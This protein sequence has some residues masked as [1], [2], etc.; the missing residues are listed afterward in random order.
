MPNL[1]ALNSHPYC[2]HSALIGERKRSWQNVNHV[3]HSFGKTVRRAR[4]EYFLYVEAG[5][6][7]G[8]VGTSLEGVWFAV[9]GVGQKWRN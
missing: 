9:L 1:V 8:V 3:L 7:K 4:R 6:G 2:G 5:V